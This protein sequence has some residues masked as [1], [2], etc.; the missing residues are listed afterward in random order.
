MA[1]CTSVLR[2]D[3]SYGPAWIQTHPNDPV[4]TGDISPSSHIARFP[5]VSHLHHFITP[6]SKVHGPFC[7]KE[8]KGFKKELHWSDIIRLHTWS[9]LTSFTKDAPEKLPFCYCSLEGSLIFNGDAS[10]FLS[11]KLSVDDEKTF[12]CW[13][14]TSEHYTLNQTHSDHIWSITTTL[15]HSPSR[16]LRAIQNPEIVHFE[17]GTHSQFREICYKNDF[18]NF[19][20][21][22][23]RTH[24][25]QYA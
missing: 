22:L 7:P 24:L 15:I 13:E 12:L 17:V 25:H 2:A 1:D 16:M 6:F 8:Q 3:Q 23:L 4:M 9:S 5:F 19:H 10:W 20:Q 18:C 21:G 11:F 14:C